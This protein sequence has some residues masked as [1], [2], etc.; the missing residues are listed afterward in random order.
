MIL[1]KKIKRIF[2]KTK[3]LIKKSSLDKRNY[4]VSS[5]KA[6]KMINFKSKVKLTHGISDLVNY[7]KKNKIRN[8][9][10][11]KYINILNSSKF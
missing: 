3:L 9:N 8:I 2:P 7:V 11:K 6:E 1:Q 4:K 10:K 5:L